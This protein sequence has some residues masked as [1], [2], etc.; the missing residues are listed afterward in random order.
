MTVNIQ[1]L[2]SFLFFATIANLTVYSLSI[3]AQIT[4]VSPESGCVREP[5]AYISP[6]LLASMASRGTFSKEGIPGAL[7]FETEFKAG[8]ITAD[9]IVQAAMKACILSNTYGVASHKHYVEEV[10]NQIQLMFRES[11]D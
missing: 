9:K 6:E 2:L 11:D 4:S 7:T 1:Q 3:K 5:Q 10:N 8:N